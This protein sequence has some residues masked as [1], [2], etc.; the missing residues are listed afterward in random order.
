MT[1]T[2]VEET[3][4]A[5]AVSQSDLKHYFGEQLF[6]VLLPQLQSTQVCG[7]VTGMLLDASPEDLSLFLHNPAMLNQVMRSCV[8]AL[9]QDD[10]CPRNVAERVRAIS[11]AN[12][13]P[14]SVFSPSSSRKRRR[15]VQKPVVSSAARVTP[16]APTAVS[17]HT[18]TQRSTT[19][20]APTAI[21]T[22]TPTQ[23]SAPSPHPSPKSSRVPSLSF[24]TPSNKTFRNS[25]KSSSRISSVEAMLLLF[26]LTS[27]LMVMSGQTTSVQL[28]APTTLLSQSHAQYDLTLGR[29]TNNE[30]IQSNL[31]T[32]A[33]YYA[34]L[35]S[36]VRSIPNTAELLSATNN[37]TDTRGYVPDLISVKSLQAI[38]A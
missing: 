35:P 21:P 33:Y 28:L 7:K 27:L 13:S 11:S 34:V 31:T 24:P 20:A 25:N 8:L 16:A 30:A 5:S 15:A 2:P 17:T 38:A 10:M 4:P 37:R 29:Q 19:P 36:P 3:K 26:S 12:R 14:S 6:A 18:H 22:H 1:F 32:S 9:Y 23:R